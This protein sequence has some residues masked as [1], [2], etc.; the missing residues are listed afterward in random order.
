VA[1]W[2]GWK[3]REVRRAVERDPRPF[4]WVDDDIDWFRSGPLSAR[5]W[6]SS[7]SI[8]NLLIAPDPQTGLLPEQLAFI[9]PFVDKHNI[10]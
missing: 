1:S 3:F 5:D 4:V 10:R 2:G 6:A 7:I 9:Q 8:P